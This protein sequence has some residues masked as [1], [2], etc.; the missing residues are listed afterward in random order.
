MSHPLVCLRTTWNY[1]VMVSNC[2]WII[3]GLAVKVDD[4][5]TEVLVSLLIKYLN[6]PLIPEAQIEAR[7]VYASVN[8]IE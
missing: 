3:Y 5:E 2:G 1:E 8:S 6:H 7:E 4:R